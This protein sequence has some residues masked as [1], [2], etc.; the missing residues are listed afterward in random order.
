L[1]VKT[2][3]KYS[4]IRASR[5]E[6]HTARHSNAETA[7][8]AEQNPVFSPGSASSTSIAVAGQVAR[9]SEDGVHTKIGGSG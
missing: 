3:V 6:R 8:F 7:E 1:A 9:H 2:A 4:G 5:H